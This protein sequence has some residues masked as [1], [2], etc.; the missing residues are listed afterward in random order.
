MITYYLFVDKQRTFEVL[1][2]LRNMDTPGISFTSIK[3]HRYLPWSIV[4]ISMYKDKFMKKWLSDTLQE[5]GYN[6]DYDIL[7]PL[8]REVALV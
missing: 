1:E 5:I 3:E 4:V 6:S 8:V 2:N 7:K